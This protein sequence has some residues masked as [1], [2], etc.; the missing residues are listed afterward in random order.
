MEHLKNKI[1]EIIHQ[2]KEFLP[3]V[4]ILL[5]GALIIHKGVNIYKD[6]LGFSG[7]F[8]EIVVSVYWSFP[9]SDQIAVYSTAI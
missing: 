6:K 5:I 8:A 3:M 1:T 9:D 4:F 7:S 2:K